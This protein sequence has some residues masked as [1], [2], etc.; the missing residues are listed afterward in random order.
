LGKSNQLWTDHFRIQSVVDLD[1]VVGQSTGY[2]V[3]MERESPPEFRRRVLAGV[4]SYKLRLK[5]IDYAL[6]RYIDADLYDNESTSLGDSVSDYLRECVELLMS[7]LPNLHTPAPTFG[8]FGAEITLFRI[9]HCLDVARML[10][11]RGLLLE[12][13]PILRLCLEMMAWSSAAFNMPNEDQVIAL[14]SLRGLRTLP[15][16]IVVQ[17]PPSILRYGHPSYA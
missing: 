6:K 11:N 1:F 3:G 12:V 16:P 10:S 5:S 9:P 13:L 2:P 8:E 14:R 7:E 17:P 4:V 15:R